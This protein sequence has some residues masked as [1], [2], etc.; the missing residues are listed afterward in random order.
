MKRTTMV[1][2]LIRLG[3]AILVIGCC[4]RIGLGRLPGDIVVERGSVTFYFPTSPTGACVRALLGELVEVA[5]QRRSY[6]TR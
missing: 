6:L 2:F 4:G 3:L 1:R 5:D